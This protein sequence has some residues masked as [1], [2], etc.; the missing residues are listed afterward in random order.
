MYTSLLLVALSA[1]SA[2]SALPAP[3][4]NGAAPAQPFCPTPLVKVPD[5]DCKAALAKV[6]LT[7]DAATPAAASG[8]CTIT[9][10]P[11]G[12]AAVK[13]TK[14]QLDAG[15]AA[16]KAK[17]GDTRGSIVVK[18]TGGDVTLA[19]SKTGARSKLTDGGNV[20]VPPTCTN[21]S[22]KIVDGDCNRAQLGLGPGGIRKPIEVLRVNGTTTTSTFGT[23]KM[24]ATAVDGAKTINCSKGRLQAGF[25][26]FRDTCG[27]FTP[28][29]LVIKGGAPGG[30][31]LL[32]FAKA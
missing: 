26:F 22:V 28:G 20:Q 29:S 9:A 31:L 27:G 18:G 13:V 12:T 1:L 15:F 19:I 6:A 32:E 14:A 21:P 4:A 10:K 17:C 5:A 25:R 24:T 16:F 11:V 2:T 3:Q 30:N 7:V 8:Q 23:C